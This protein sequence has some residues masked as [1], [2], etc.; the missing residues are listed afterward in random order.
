MFCIKPI[1]GSSK[2]SAFGYST[3]RIETPARDE[4]NTFFLST[5]GTP[6]YNTIAMYL[7][8]FFILKYVISQEVKM[9][10]QTAIYMVQYKYR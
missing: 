4:K 3:F 9:K 7:S 8:F 6:I 10:L 1:Y 5:F 2:K